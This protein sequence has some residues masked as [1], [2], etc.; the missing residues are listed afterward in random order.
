METKKMAENIFSSVVSESPID[1]E[2]NTVLVIQ[3]VVLVT[4]VNDG[5]VVGSGLNQ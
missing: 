5:D 2:S 1:S 4:P 3:L